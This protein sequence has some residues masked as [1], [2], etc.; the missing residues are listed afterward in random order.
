MDETACNY[1]PIYTDDAGNCYYAEPY[2][3]CDGECLVDT[4][5]DG[6]CDPLEI[7]G[8]T[9]SAF[10]DYNPSAT[11]DDGTCGTADQINDVCQGAASLSCGET[12]LMNNEECAT[13]DD[14]IGCAANLPPDR[15]QGCGSLL[16]GRVIPSRSPPVFQ[17]QSSIPICLSMQVHA[18][19]CHV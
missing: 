1:D 11:D 9:D 7:P 17:E 4:D 5:G 3:D 14:E 19:I 16:K 15:P 6:V 12:L 10:C 18:V 2:Y 13:I 8:C